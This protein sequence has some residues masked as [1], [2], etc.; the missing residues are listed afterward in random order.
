[1]AYAM[2]FSP[3]IQQLDRIA[4][5]ALLT[6]ALSFTA[7]AIGTLIGTAGAIAATY[8]RS[9]V[10]RAVAVYVESI[11]N[12]PFLV[13]L[14]LIFFGL[15][16]VG[17]QI[18]ALSAALLAMSINLGAYATEI[19]RS[20]VQAIH[21]TQIEAASA[22]AMTRW[23]TIRH[24]V[25]VPAFE[26]V[27]PALASQFTLMMLTS[28]VVSTISVEELTSIASQIDSLT[29]RTFETYILMMAI[30]VGLALLLRAVFFGIGLAVFKRR[31]R[32]EFFAGAAR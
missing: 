25:L 6:L 16:S 4:G 13:Q 28:S 5:G 24:V 32:V 17:L 21:R 12:T 1:M 23:Q 18:D 31:R 7:I 29:F 9:W 19:I 27:Y 22:L 26:K 15:P 20:G 11:R 3:L 8:G 30:Y 14:F 10:Q 2:D